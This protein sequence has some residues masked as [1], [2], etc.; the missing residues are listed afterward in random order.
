MKPEEKY[1]K[2]IAKAKAL[3]VENEKGKT[4]F[5]PRYMFMRHVDYIIRLE[6]EILERKQSLRELG[7]E[8]D[9]YI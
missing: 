8:P 4:G 7:M 5:T 9:D 2:L 1:A 6:Y 3:D